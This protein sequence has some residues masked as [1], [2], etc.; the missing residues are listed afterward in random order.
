MAE[1]NKAKRAFYEEASLGLGKIFFKMGLRPNF[2]TAVSFGCGIVSG[3]YFWYGYV[4]WG[5]IW[6]IA[7]T[8]NFNF[9]R[10]L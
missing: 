10:S 3:L 2:W 5:I 7:N 4:F 6:M 8:L 9:T 1:F